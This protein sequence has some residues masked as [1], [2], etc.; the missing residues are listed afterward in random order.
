MRARRRRAAYAKVV[1]ELDD[2]NSDG[3][4]DSDLDDD[5]YPTLFYCLKSINCHI[6]RL[7]FLSS[8][9]I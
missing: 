8:R 6:D 2:G 1:D 7:P 3:S 9:D 5:L 4:D